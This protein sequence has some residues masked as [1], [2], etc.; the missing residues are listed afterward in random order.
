M[1]ISHLRGGDM[2]SFITRLA[3]MVLLMSSAA[4]GQEGGSPGPAVPE[5]ADASITLDGGIIAL[6]I[7]YEWVHGTLFYHGQVY[8]FQV[9]G[10]SFIDLGAAK[11]RGSGE[12]F[13][14]KSVSDFQGDYAGSTFGSAVSSGASLALFTNEHGVRIR[15]RSTIS[16]VRLNFSGNVLRIRLA[17]P[18]LPAGAP[19]PNIAAVP[20]PHSED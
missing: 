20:S 1:P 3:A 19:S 18:S 17:K 13:N 11:I 9:R 8:P 15:A 5:V 10:L 2:R 12:V 4:S 6:G 7:G 14:L 16:G